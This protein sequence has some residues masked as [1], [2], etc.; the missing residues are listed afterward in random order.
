MRY[1]V[2]PD[3]TKYTPSTLYFVDCRSSTDGVLLIILHANLL[4]KFSIP[5]L[6]FPQRQRTFARA[7]AHNIQK[8]KPHPLVPKPP[9]YQS[10]SPIVNQSNPFTILIPTPRRSPSTTNDR[11]IKLPITNP[12][13]RGF[14]FRNPRKYMAGFRW[15]GRG[16]VQA[17]D[18]GLDWSVHGEMGQGSL[19]P[20]G[21][22]FDCV[23]QNW[24]GLGA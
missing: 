17:M 24:C 11:P 8:I 18:A 19:R 23:R 7:L 13:P 22:L 9:K 10:I 1:G 21:L 15:R 5:S 20:V 3:Y 2:F 12:R 14:C 4:L 16:K 6:G